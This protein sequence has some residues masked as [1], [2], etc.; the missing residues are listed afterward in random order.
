MNE[1]DVEK[2]VEK[3]LEAILGKEPFSKWLLEK[4]QEK[5]VT[6]TASQFID[7]FEKTGKYVKGGTWTT[8]CHSR[9]EFMKELG[10]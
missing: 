7:A 6:I 10:F 9:D 8:Y 3:K 4:L 2:L 5:R 1:N